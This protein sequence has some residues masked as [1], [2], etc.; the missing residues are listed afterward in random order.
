MQKKIQHL[1][2]GII[3]TEHS[4]ISRE[5]DDNIY[6]DAGIEIAVATTK[7]FTAQIF[8]LMLLAVKNSRLKIPFN[9]IHTLPQLMEEFLNQDYLEYSKKISAYAKK[10]NSIFFIGKDLDYYLAIEGALKLKEISYINAVAYP[11]GELKH[12]SISLIKENFPTIAIALNDKVSDKTINSCEEV[13][14]RGSYVLGITNKKEI[15]SIDD[16]I[17]IKNNNIFI[18]PFLCL[19][20]MQMIAYNVALLRGNDIDKPKNLAKSVTVE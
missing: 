7:A 3:N 5:A 1:P 4:S 16:N 18:Y 8:I 9:I 2:C 14:A 10:D 13:K 20:S 11:A 12:G 15:G 6:T 17:Y 19:I